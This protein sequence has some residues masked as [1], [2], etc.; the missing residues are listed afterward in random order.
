MKDTVNSIVKALNLVPHPEGG[1]YKEVYRSANSLPQEALP[2]N[3]NGSRNYCTSIYFLL[4]A[5]NFSAFHRIQQDEVW[6]FYSG[7]PLIVHVIDKEGRYSANLVGLDFNA[8]IHPQFVVPAGAWFAS[9]VVDGGTYSLVG[10]TVAPGF[11]FDDFELADRATLI[12]KYPQHKEIITK[13]T[14]R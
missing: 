8:S 7:S 13:Y 1:Y 11:D 3:F 12:Q 2:S 4:T 14:R 9:S 5:T 6:H 10:C